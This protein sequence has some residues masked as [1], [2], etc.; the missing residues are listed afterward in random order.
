M[1]VAEKIK[2]IDNEIEQNKAQ[3]NLERLAA[4][5]LGFSSCNNGGYE[6]LTDED[7][8]SEKGLL[9]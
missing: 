5:I 3:Y 7:A 9:E 4:K 2:T 8:L 6:L 1:T